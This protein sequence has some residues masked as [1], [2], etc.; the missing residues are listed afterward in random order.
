M[1]NYTCLEWGTVYVTNSAISLVCDMILF[2]IPIAIISRLQCS[3]PRKIGLSFVLM[4]G[5]LVIG[6]SCTRMYLVIVGQWEADESWSYDPLLAIEV[7]EIGSTLIALSIPALKPICGSVFRSIS[8]SLEHFFGSWATYGRSKFGTLGA[9]D[10]GG[11]RTAE[12][13]PTYS[14]TESQINIK[15][16][17]KHSPIMTGWIGQKAAEEGANGYESEAMQYSAAAFHISQGR[18][19]SVGSDVSQEPTIRYKV[20]YSVPYVSRAGTVTGAPRL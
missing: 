5:L 20:K 2:A 10:H 1:S 18:D 13:R 4:P 3:T 16:N 14:S 8:D 11:S 7:S 19:P 15:A 12:L 9:S 6:V 17:T